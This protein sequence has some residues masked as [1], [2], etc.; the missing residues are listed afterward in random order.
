MKI[1]ILPSIVVLFA[2][3]TGTALTVGAEKSEAK[4]ET[5]HLA[6]VTEYIRQLAAIENI[7]ASSEQEL[8]QATKDQFF[9]SLDLHPFEHSVS[10]RTEI[11]GR[12]VERHAS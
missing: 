5:P 12:H 7:R 11:T 4:P 6:F 3:A 1:K 8:K 10:T 9:F 2:L